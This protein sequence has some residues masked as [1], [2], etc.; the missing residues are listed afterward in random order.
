MTES[1]AENKVA[2]IHYTL[3]D[4]A[5]EV[6]D[7]SKEGP[8]LAYLHGASNLVPGL[9]KEMTGRE[10]GSSFE[11]KVSAAEGYGERQGPGPQAVHR[12]EFPKDFEPTEGRPLRAQ[13]GEGNMITL[14]ITKV[15]GA[16][17]WVDVNHPLAGQTLNFDVE[18][19]SMRD[20]TDDEKEHGHAHGLH[21]HAHHH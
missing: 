20:A 5:G 13:D 1:I 3:R 2:L 18:V 4:P 11:V 6:L 7:S 16:Q 17:V 12:S 15:E 19:M 10:V 9:E 14:W 21:G 8:P